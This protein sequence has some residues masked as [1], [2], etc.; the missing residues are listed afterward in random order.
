MAERQAENLKAMC[1]IHIIGNI[2]Y[3]N[4]NTNTTKINKFQNKNIL[5]FHNTTNFNLF[6]NKKKNLFTNAVLK[7]K[8]IFKQKNLKI[9]KKKI[10][11]INIFKNYF[12]KFNNKLKNNSIILF[13]L[14]KNFFITHDLNF[15]SQKLIFLL[16]FFSKTQLMRLI[17]NLILLNNKNY[18]YIFNYFKISGMYIKISG[19]FNG[20]GGAKK[21]KKHIILHK[22][23]F[24]DKN[25][26]IKR[27]ITNIR[28]K[29]GLTT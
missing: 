10:K 28:H 24:N 13:F 7:N 5:N 2:F 16:F 9:N 23:K 29:V 17:R 15:F 18:E 22:I 26:K 3:I 27:S 11:I 21:L 8:I 20:F 19:K 4:I 1:S 12:I 14:I 25:I 6:F